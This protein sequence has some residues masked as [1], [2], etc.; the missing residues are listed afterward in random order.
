MQIK[1]LNPYV[2]VYCQ[3]PEFPEAK[4]HALLGD[5]LQN[6]EIVHLENK[7]RE[8]KSCRAACWTKIRDLHVYMQEMRNMPPYKAALM[9][10]GISQSTG[11]E[12]ELSE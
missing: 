5:G 4:L 10:L 2:Y 12:G 3:N 11:K 9:T 1:E 8:G 7:G 6:G